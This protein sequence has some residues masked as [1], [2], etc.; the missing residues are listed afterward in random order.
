MTCSSTQS[1]PGEQGKEAVR[2]AIHGFLTALSGLP[3]AA[4]A[5]PRL[6]ETAERFNLSASSA[7]M[8]AFAASV[9]RKSKNSRRNH[10]SFSKEKS[11]F[12]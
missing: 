11:C 8:C 5:R 6:I 10:E 2:K 12:C 9:Y 3:I 4:L 1:Q 7:W